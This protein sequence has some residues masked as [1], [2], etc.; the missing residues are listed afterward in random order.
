MPLSPVTLRPKPKSQG[1][2]DDLEHVALGE[3]LN[4]VDRDDVQEHV[5]ER[6]RGDFL[7]L[8]AFRGNGQPAAGLEDVGEHEADDHGDG[9]G[10]EVIG[11]RLACYAPEL[12]YVADAGRT[13]DEGG[14]HER[15]HE[16]CAP[17]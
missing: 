9:R 17:D 16:P 7:G 15:H 10:N 3:S 11:Q 8:E 1:E 13:R 2:E 14:Q 5:D 4:G 6:G 12:A